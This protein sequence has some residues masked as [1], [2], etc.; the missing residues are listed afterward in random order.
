MSEETNNNQEDSSMFADVETTLDKRKIPVKAQLTVIAVLLLLILG[1]G[2]LPGFF[3]EDS[4]NE[5]ATTEIQDLPSANDIS[6]DPFT[7]LELL[8]ESA[9][10]WDVSKNETLYEKEP[11]KSWP[12]AS[13]TKLMTVML[14]HELVEEDKLAVVSENAT[15]QA[16]ESGLSAGERFKFRTLS[17]LT[18][19]S[20][21]ND[22][23]YALAAS[24]GELLDPDEPAD[25]FVRTMNIRADE[26]NLSQTFFRNPTGLDL[27]EDEAGAYGSAR[28]VTFLMSYILKN[29]PEILE[30]ST[31]PQD[32]LPDESGLYHQADNTNP[33]V[34]DLPGL[35]GS[36]TGYT[37][38][39]GGN[40][41]VAFDASLNRPVV[42]SVL[43]SSYQGRFSDVLKLVEATRAKIL[44]EE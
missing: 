21:S 28:D 23:A 32:N 12:L 29:Y 13:I 19:L 39:A 35:I 41:V 42:V 11:D 3:T 1:G 33:I 15:E 36:K 9:F 6:S 25:A 44:M 40:L 26:L 22:G 7:D 20:S 2:F 8:A 24:T 38:L 17:D 30:A 14:S 10:V 31:K 43:G 16:G 5:V 27:S 34:N 37:T 4:E 18:I